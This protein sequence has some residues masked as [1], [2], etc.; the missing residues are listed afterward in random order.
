[1]VDSGTKVSAGSDGP[2]SV[3]VV[4]AGDSA[5]SGAAAAVVEVGS[6]D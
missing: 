4:A 2:S 3:I 6:G 1:V 5:G